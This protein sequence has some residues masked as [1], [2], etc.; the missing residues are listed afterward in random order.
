MIGRSRVAVFA[1]GRRFKEGQESFKHDPRPGQ[2]STTR[3]EET[4]VPLRENIL[5]DR[6]LITREIADEINIL[7]ALR[8]SSRSSWRDTFSI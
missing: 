7:Y 1:N 6:R 2:P 8:N 3:N 5:A 4:V